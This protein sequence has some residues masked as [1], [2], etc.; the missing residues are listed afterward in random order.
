MIYCKKKKKIIHY[1][2]TGKRCVTF[3]FQSFK[4]KKCPI[5][6]NL[7]SWH[8]PTSC[9]LSLAVRPMLVLGRDQVQ[10]ASFA[11]Q[12]PFQRIA[13]TLIWFRRE[14]DGT[15]LQIRRETYGLVVIDVCLH[16]YQSVRTVHA[17]LP[18]I[19]SSSHGTSVPCI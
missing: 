19:C 2:P 5:C 6:L 4:C 14:L 18:H 9:S 13:A 3:V 17:D 10:M 11:K 7:D 15:D 12:P 16:T 1:H 8:F